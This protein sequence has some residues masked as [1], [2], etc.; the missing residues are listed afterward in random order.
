MYSVIQWL[1]RSSVKRKSSVARSK[2]F[3]VTGTMKR[4]SIILINES[5]WTDKLTIRDKVSVIPTVLCNASY[6]YFGDTCVWVYWMIVIT[7]W[8]GSISRVNWKEKDICTRWPITGIETASS[9][10]PTGPKWVGYA[11]A[12]C[13]SWL[14][15]HAWITHSHG[16][17]E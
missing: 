16:V 13:H 5:P 8:V 11:H 6:Q 14:L 10:T 4:R 2:C 3:E 15:L 1:K 17:N 7:S 9:K 12:K